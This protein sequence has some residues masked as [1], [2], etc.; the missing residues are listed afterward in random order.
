M[1]G[2]VTLSKKEWNAIV[3]YLKDDEEVLISS[4]GRYVN[5]P[6]SKKARWRH[7]QRTWKKAYKAVVPHSFKTQQAAMA[8]V[9]RVERKKR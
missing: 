2:D 6:R 9:E 8:V 3:Q 1:K 4:Y 5:G 7:K